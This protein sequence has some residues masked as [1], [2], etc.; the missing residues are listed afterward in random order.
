MNN[1]IEIEDIHRWL[2]SLYLE[3]KMLQKEIIKLRE[4]LE[5]IKEGLS[6]D[7]PQTKG[8]EKGET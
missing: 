2:G 1:Q 6:E 3:N 4:E 5:Q 8:G 7:S